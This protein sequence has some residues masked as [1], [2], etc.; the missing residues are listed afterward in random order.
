[1]T[2]KLQC[3]STKD[4]INRDWDFENCNLFGAYDLLFVI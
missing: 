3:P 4:R 1:M 2:N